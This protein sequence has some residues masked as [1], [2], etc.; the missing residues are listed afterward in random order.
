MTELKLHIV[1]PDGTLVDN[2][3]VTAVRLPGAQAPFTVLSGHAP[4]ISPLLAGTVTYDTSEGTQSL[5][6]RSGF[7]RVLDNRVE[8]AVE[9]E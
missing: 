7:V 2:V 3:P 5:A 9:T 4:I 1:S 6:I 8:L